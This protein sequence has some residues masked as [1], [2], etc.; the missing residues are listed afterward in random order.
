MDKELVH[1]SKRLLKRLQR[2]DYR[3]RYTRI[4]CFQKQKEMKLAIIYKYYT[5]LHKEDLLHGKYIFLK[6]HSIISDQQKNKRL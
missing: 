5:K 2:S 3:V 1:L 4:L 6:L